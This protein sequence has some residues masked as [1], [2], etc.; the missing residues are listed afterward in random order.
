M[1]GDEDA[2]GSGRGRRVALA[3]VLIC[4][5]AFGLFAWQAVSAARALMDV[6]QD[7]EQVR[8]EIQA[9]DF[10]AATR[11]LDRLGR[12]TAK[13]HDA[14]DGALWDLGRRIPLVG[15]NIA[16]V[17]TSSSVVDTVARRNAP[18]A[19]ELS[20]L[21]Q[22]GGLRPVD[23]KFDLAPVTELTPAVAKAAHSIEEAS[24]A[25]DEVDP[26]DLIFP[27]NDLVADLTDQV[28]RARSATSAA[29]DAFALLP[30][31]LGTEGPRDYLLIIQNPA[32]LRS[33][34]GLPGALA[35][36]HA[37]KGRLTM[38]W[39]GTAS[40]L[41]RPGAP[42]VRVRK[43][44]LARYGPTTGTDL[45]DVNFTPDF[46]EAARIARA[47][48]ARVQGVK[49]D[50][51]ISVD[52]IA[53]SAVLAA[54]GP[55]EVRPGVSLNAQNVVATLLNTTYQ[56]MDDPT[57]QNDFFAVAARK[58]F[59]AVVAGRGDQ[60]QA[61][62]ALANAVG[63][64]RVLLWSA[65]EAEQ[66]R[67][68]GTPIAGGLDDTD[69]TSPEVGIYLN[70]SLAGKIDYYLQYRSTASPVACRVG[71]SQDLRATVVLTSAV[72][73]DFAKLSP[74]IVGDGSYAP[75]GTIA[76]NMRIYAPAGGTVTGLEVDGAFHSVTA[77]RHHGRQVAFLPLSLEPGQQVEVVA[78][79]RTAKGQDADGT[80]NV[81]PG[82]VQAPNGVR[83]ASACR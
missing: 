60:E 11:S 35:V 31:M 26:D 16:A 47:M 18:V 62:K 67:L 3:L 39:Q 25:L 41:V 79:I 77:D 52:P 74:W 17:Q 5:F 78:E 14:T 6:R 34:G 46:P 58:V 27:L 82:M 36:L 38:G 2:T 68:V 10:D 72:P 13:A 61:I 24:A 1:S 37:D 48:L 40:D 70:D 56:V 7:A 21:L 64:H 33:T 54:T 32:E 42:A 59:E 28:E 76:V 15:K 44:T 50:G 9:G 63:E 43:D 29:A 75:K 49:V 57:A 73:K 53:L 8:A 83:I 51:V 22:E 71:G 45:R 80:L 23:G 65:H 55:V 69:P 81:T 4:C 12:S 66:A 30:A 20:R 19:I